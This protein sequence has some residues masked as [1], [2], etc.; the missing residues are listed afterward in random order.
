MDL[1]VL[2]GSAVGLLASWIV[3]SCLI[4]VLR[5]RF[6]RDEQADSDPFSFRPFR[7]GGRGGRPARS[8]HP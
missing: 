5:A 6:S 8:S 2:V 4:M 1:V 7:P 3:L